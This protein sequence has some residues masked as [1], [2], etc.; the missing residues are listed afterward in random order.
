L[1]CDQGNLSLA[2]RYNSHT[3]PNRRKMMIMTRTPRMP[4]G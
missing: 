4:L 3:P 1:I 2:S